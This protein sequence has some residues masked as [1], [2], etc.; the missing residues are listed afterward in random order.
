MNLH[1]FVQFGPDQGMTFRVEPDETI[2]I[3][4]GSSTKTGLTDSRVS[5]KHCQLAYT[6]DRITLEDV[7]SSG[8]T[9][10][11]GETISGAVEVQIG[12]VIR[13]GRTELAIKAGDESNASIGFSLFEILASPRY[14]TE[15]FQDPL[16]GQTLHNFKI[17]RQLARS[18]N[19]AVYYATCVDD[20][21][22]RA[23]KVL[24]DEVLADEQSLQR[25]MRAMRIMQEIHHPNIVQV[26]D[27]GQNGKHV[28]VSMEYVDGQSAADIVDR[29]TPDSY[30]KGALEIGLHITRALTEAAAR[31]I[32]HRKINPANILIRQADGLAKLGGLMLAKCL[33]P[34]AAEPK[35]SQGNEVLEDLAYEPPEATFGI[36]NLDTRSDIYSLGAVLFATLTGRP[37]FTA[38]FP[39]D[40]FQQLRESNCPRP[41]ELG[42]EMP[43][44]FEAAVMK[45]L[46]KQPDD[47]YQDPNE[48][49]KALTR[50]A[51]QNRVAIPWATD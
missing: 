24:S 4:R 33:S 41:S 2:L 21:S 19:G 1:L 47:R 16:L 32:V 36:K 50:V 35:V 37:P 49:L 31:N 30:W 18:S 8:G 11:N 22:P 29:V 39:A 20:G 9:K 51:S 34:A 42:V 23:V 5:R 38:D 46:E 44:D 45:M 10:V 12:D 7:G 43:K 15:V 26:H 48:L 40:L 3:G 27:S 13:V 25:F 17:E 14:S 28:W 6:D